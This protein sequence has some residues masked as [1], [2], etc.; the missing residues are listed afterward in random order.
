VGEGQNGERFNRQIKA[1]AAYAEMIGEIKS[2]RRDLFGT[3]LDPGPITRIATD[4]NDLK[5]NPMTRLGFFL[6]GAG[7][8]TAAAV[9]FLGGVVGVAWTTVSL[10]HHFHIGGL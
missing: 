10:A 6:R 9:M 5:A 1:T 3:E 8:S 2:L 7:R 4:I